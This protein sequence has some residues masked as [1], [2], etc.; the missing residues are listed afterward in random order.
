MA[1]FP[2]ILGGRVLWVWQLGL[3]RS[4]E[5]PFACGAGCS[6]PSSASAA[7]E[8]RLQERSLLLPSPPQRTHHATS[9]G[10]KKKLQSCFNLTGIKSSGFQLW[11]ISTPETSALI[12]AQSPQDLRFN[13]VNTYIW[14]FFCQKLVSISKRA[15]DRIRKKRSGCHLVVFF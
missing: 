14:L 12:C 6:V 10:K 8:Q 3:L 4:L 7:C 11:V 2:H 13:S 5:S 9:V 1:L 15:R